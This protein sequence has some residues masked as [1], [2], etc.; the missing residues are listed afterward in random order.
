MKTFYK[1]DQS[2]TFKNNLSNNTANILKN[3]FCKKKYSNLNT[4]NATWYN[5]NNDK[6]KEPLSLKKRQIK[7]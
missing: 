1:N 6:N 3:F 7:L 2:K 5:S 4:I